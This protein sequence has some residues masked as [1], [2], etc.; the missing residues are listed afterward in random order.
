[1]IKA[2]HMAAMSTELS[3]AIEAVIRK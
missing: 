1:L 2:P 3:A